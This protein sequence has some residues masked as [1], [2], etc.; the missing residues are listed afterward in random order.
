[1]T[2]PRFGKKP[3]NPTPGRPA[4]LAAFGKDL[5][6]SHAVATSTGNPHAVPP[7]TIKSVISLDGQWSTNEYWRGD[8]QLD[9]GHLTPLERGHVYRATFSSGVGA[10]QVSGLRVLD[11]EGACMIEGLVATSTN[12]AVRTRW[13]AKK[14]IPQY[15][16]SGFFLAEADLLTFKARV[17]E[18]GGLVR[19][20]GPLR[21]QAASGA[22]SI[23]VSVASLAARANTAL[24]DLP[25]AAANMTEDNWASESGR[26]VAAVTAVTAEKTELGETISE[27]SSLLSK[28]K[29]PLS[30]DM[31]MAV[32]VIE[33]AD[34]AWRS[35]PS[36]DRVGT[37]V[38]SR[39]RGIAAGAP[40]ADAV[41]TRYALDAAIANV[42]WV[43]QIAS[44]MTLTEAVGDGPKRMNLRVK[45]ADGVQV[46]LVLRKG[47]LPEVEVQSGLIDRLVSEEVERRATAGRADVVA[48]GRFDLE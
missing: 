2:L 40:V 7:L 42:W 11:E 32:A 19:V 16:G 3:D 48:R 10:W 24:A 35:I 20:Q 26:I 34:V 14:H 27:W 46:S 41:T 5:T 44:Q 29:G 17:E 43:A 36:L 21:G 12:E 9:E 25:L 28:A 18:I 38:T 47:A 39:I 33:Q 31:L 8:L 1:M 4:P 30:P 22:R 37:A 6:P 23:A 13:A 45:G 15:M